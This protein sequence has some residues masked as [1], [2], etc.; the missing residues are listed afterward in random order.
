MS[1]AKHELPVGQNEQKSG[2]DSRA[3]WERPIV[4][5]LAASEAEQGAGPRGDHGSGSRS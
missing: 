3:V 4:R 2:D 5:R 1:S